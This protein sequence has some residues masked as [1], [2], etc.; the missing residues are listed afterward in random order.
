MRVAQSILL[1]KAFAVPCRAIE[2]IDGWAARMKTGEQSEW[3]IPADQPSRVPARRFTPHY[4][5]DELGFIDPA[6]SS[7]LLDAEG[8]LEHPAVLIKAQ[9][10]MGKTT[11]ATEM[12]AWL[13]EDAEKKARFGSFCELTCFEEDIGVRQPLPPWW[14][15][16]KS[17]LP[18]EPACWIID[19]LDECEP[20]HQGVLKRI[21]REIAEVPAKSHRSKLRL[22]FLSRDRA[23]LKGFED[24]L[25]PLYAEVGTDGPLVLRMAPLDRDEAAR[26]LGSSSAFDRVAEII[27][28]YDG[29]AGIAGY[30]RV[31]SF[32]GEWKGKGPLTPADV[33]KAILMDL[34]EEHNR[35]KARRFSTELEHRFD[36][37]ARIAAVTMLSGQHDLYLSG[38]ESTSP[39]LTIG[40]VFPLASLADRPEAMRV[41]ARESIR[42]GGPFRSSIEGGFRFGQR[43]IRDWFC[44]F[45]LRHLELERLRAA[46]ADD[47]G[48]LPYLAD[49]LHLLK[50]AS[51]E[52]D[53]RT[54]LASILAALGPSSGYAPWGLEEA[55][56]QLDHLEVIASQSPSNLYIYDD[57]QLTRLEAPGLGKRVAGRLNDANRPATVRKLLMDIAQALKIRE[58][59]PPAL[60]IVLDE[61]QD[62]RLRERAAILVRRLGTAKDAARLDGPIAR[63]GGESADARSLRAQAI[64]TLLEHGVWSVHQAARAAPRENPRGNRYYLISHLRDGEARDG[65]RRPIDC[66]R[67]S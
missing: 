52:P 36:A 27:E 58:A 55:L 62:I 31:L 33:W 45:G 57:E 16:W 32:L 23:W 50:Q 26:M 59:V 13:C 19:G 1:Y 30:P 21:V 12:H 42:I 65:G 11:F 61:T 47:R 18:G 9:P 28:Q 66:Y 37:V 7:S 29:L 3:P 25:R 49:M 6:S 56:L 35:V 22:I 54:W 14:S 67:L 46:V 64:M 48:P 38:S 20:D 60:R 51:E 43:N 41:A 4:G 5:R 2:F 34:L 39:A 10:W 53:V 17:L 44:A 63:A 40:D 15:Q 24:E 8:L